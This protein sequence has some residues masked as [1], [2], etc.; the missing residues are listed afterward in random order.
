MNPRTRNATI[1]LVLGAALVGLLLWWNSRERTIADVQVNEAIPS[2]AQVVILADL[3][4]IRTSPYES[5][6]AVGTVPSM[7]PGAEQGCGRNLTNRVESLALWAPAEPGASFGIAA[8]APV[9]VDAVWDCA[10]ST[11][12]G[13]GGQPTFTEVEGFRIIKDEKL[14]PG[15]AQ[16]AVR[17]PGLLLLGRPA[18]RSRMMDA[19]AGRTAAASTTGDHDRMRKALGE[20]GEL[21]VTVVVS[22]PLRQRIARWLGEPLPLLGQ[23]TFLAATADLEATT[24]LRATVWCTSAQACEEVAERLRSKRRR[25][26]DS[27]AMRAIGVAGLLQDAS[28][29]PQGDRVDVR[30]KAPADQVLALAKRIEALEQ[31]LQRDRTP[32]VP[33][34]P[35]SVPDE[36]LRP[37]R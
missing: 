12:A 1:F 15:S 4:R 31:W 3:A 18:T 5:L 6:F 20:V 24:H 36:T 21:T 34:P 32:P 29:A 23:V 30:A 7:M 8:R 11:I 10:Q 13:R 28:F 19:L 16:I 22:P 27:L 25:I 2:D 35:A 33:R 26:L 37:D 14:G 17:D 9:T